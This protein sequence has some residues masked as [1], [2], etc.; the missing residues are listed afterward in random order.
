[1]SSIEH[2]D[3][4]NLKSFIDRLIETSRCNGAGL[5]EALDGMPIIEHY[6]GRARPELAAGPNVLWP[7]ASISKLYTAAAI[8]GLVE[9]GDLTLGI[10]VSN[11]L[12][13]FTGGGRESVTLQAAVE[14]YVRRAI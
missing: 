4:S 10:R 8:T 1:M 3:Y 11:V 9:Q 2:R 14:A 13:G 5:A 6:A 12:P 7:I